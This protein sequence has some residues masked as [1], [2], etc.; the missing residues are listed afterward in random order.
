MNPESWIPLF[1]GPIKAPI[2]GSE[3]HFPQDCKPRGG[4]PYGGPLRLPP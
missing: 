2:G 3:A 4:R 1:K